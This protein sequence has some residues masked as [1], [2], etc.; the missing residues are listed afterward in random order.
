MDF[1]SFQI[2]TW[3]FYKSGFD[4]IWPLW[5]AVSS[6][7]VLSNDAASVGVQLGVF[8][9]NQ[10]DNEEYLYLNYNGTWK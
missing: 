10:W 5:T 9:Q 4:H 6:I 7:T 2:R 1:Q 8:E 3:S